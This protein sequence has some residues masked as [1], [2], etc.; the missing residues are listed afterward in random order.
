ML[1]SSLHADYNPF[2]GAAVAPNIAEVRLGSQ[3]ISVQLEI[4]IGD[5]SVFEALIPDD[6]VSES[7]ADRPNATERLEDFG[8]NGL[9][10]RRDDGSALAVKLQRIEPRMRINRAPP[11]AGQRDP[12][13]GQIL[14]QPPEDKRVI[15]AE[16]FYDFEGSRPESVT[17]VPPQNKDRTPS[18]IIGLLVF[19]RSVPVIKFSFLSNAARLAIDWSDPWYSLFDNPNLRRH[20]QSALTTYL[21]LEPR[22]VRHETLIR[23]RDLAAWI[24]LGVNDAT[25]LSVE[26]QD[27][28]KSLALGFLKDRNPVTINGKA[29][30]PASGR[31]SFLTI[32]DVGLQIVENEGPLDPLST[33]V[34]VI[35]SFPVPELP[36]NAAVDWDMFNDRIVMV[37]AT[38]TDPAGPFLS[39]ATPDSPNIEWTNFLRTHQDPQ[40]RPVQTPGHGQIYVPTI[41]LGLIAA[42]LLSAFLAFARLGSSRV[43]ALLVLLAGAGSAVMTRHAA[44]VELNNPLVGAPDPDSTARIFSALLENINS[45]NL[46][47]DPAIE[48]KL[49]ETV[50]SEGS[51]STIMAELDRALSVRI[52]GGGLARVDTISDVSMSE[53]STLPD[54]AG[55]QSLAEWTAI[56]SAGHWG[57]DHRR[58]L[59]Y[60]AL[61]EV[62]REQGA[63]KLAG[64]TVIETSDLR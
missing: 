2:N 27:R 40:V 25:T 19:D 23:V 3:G 10:I 13:T 7:S 49:L 5:I 50:L 11:W 45:A 21:Y 30:K 6:W 22:E 16:L 28:I 60:R 48:L 51:K 42:A 53:I 62:A 52:A 41:S 57:H 32:S 55:F 24:D 54:R 8:L 44:I 20:H 63:W 18:A 38:L 29:V 61:V 35:L 31:A 26:N 33:F 39:G 43:V 12:I 34:G 46:E 58:N 37:P 17:I 56:A 4:Y 64:I 47:T 14:P 59:R 1:G 36:Q 15:F 9:S